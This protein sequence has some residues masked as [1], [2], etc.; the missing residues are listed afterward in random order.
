[1][2]IKFYRMWALVERDLRKFFRSPALMMSSM[3]FPMMQLIV[4][5]YAFGGKIR[6]VTVGIVDQDHTEMSWQVEEAFAGVATGPKMFHIIHYPAMPEAMKDLRTGGI[7]A[8]VNIPENFSRRAYN[9]NRPR[10]GLVVD[11]SD[12]ITSSSLES[13]LQSVV[14]QL[15]VNM[16]AQLNLG[17]NPMITS[18][19][20]ASRLPGAIALDTVEVYPYVEYIK[21]LLPGSIAMAVF[22]VAMIGGGITFIDDKSRGLHEGYLVTPIHK[23]ELVMGLDLAGTAKGLMAGL[24]ITFIGGMIAGIPQ[25]WN[26][27]R[28]FYLIIVV[29]VA[30]LCMISFMFLIMVRIDDPL[31]PRAIFG[32]LNTLLFFPSGSIYPTYGF[33]FWLRWISVVDPFTYTVDALRNLL[34]RGSGIE[35]IYQDVLILAGFSAVMIAGSIALF[36][37]QI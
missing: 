19:P 3:I 28:L 32:V 5:G 22:I 6:D 25:L 12:Q 15:N 8:I 34:L 35:G 11:N 13:E 18:G 27:V 30:S 4:L 10:L 36:K 37:R 29:S 23:A 20:L 14:D 21:Y 2:N 31:V 7:G 17:S 9:E 16:A 26:P 1:M 24:V 33:P